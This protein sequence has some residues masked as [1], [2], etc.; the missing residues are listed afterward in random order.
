MQVIGNA[1]KQSIVIFIY[2]PIWKKVST[3]EYPVYNC[4]DRM[5]TI[6]KYGSFFCF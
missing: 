4:T 5:V 2:V 6:K 3:S 1:N